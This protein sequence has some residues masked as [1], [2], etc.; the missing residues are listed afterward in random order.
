MTTSTCEGAFIVL[1]VVENMWIWIFLQ[2]LDEHVAQQ[3]ICQEK[4]CIKDPFN[5]CSYLSSLLRRP[6][7]RYVFGLLGRIL[8]WNPTLPV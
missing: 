5:L 8:K 4:S 1:S 7:E 2:G 3:K 6:K